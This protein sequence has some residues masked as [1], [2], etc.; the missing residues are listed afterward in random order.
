VPELAIRKIVKIVEQTRQ[1]IGRALEK[2]T[3]MVAIAAVL[4]NPWAN[5]GYVEDL[6]STIL[7]LAPKLGDELV[8]MLLDEIGGADAVQAYGKAAVVGMRGEIEHA[9]GLIHTLRFGNKFRDAVGGKTFL[10]F[11]NRRG[12]PGGSIQVPMAHKLDSG[13][14]SHYITMEFSIADAPA[15]DE[16]VVVIAASTGGRAF[17]RIGNRYIDVEEMGLSP[18]DSR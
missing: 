7:A 12:G 5:Q 1:E 6:R 17:P 3:E 9:S 16:I 10:S 14:R 11:T 4:K 8:P 15:D 2:P 13:Q 18:Q